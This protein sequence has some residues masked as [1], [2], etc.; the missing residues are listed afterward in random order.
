MERLIK[1]LETELSGG[2]EEC[3]LEK[4]LLHPL[5]E[6]AD[7][8]TPHCFHYGINIAGGDGDYDAK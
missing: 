4:Q 2:G 3:A 5:D 1:T 7:G 6:G 8:A